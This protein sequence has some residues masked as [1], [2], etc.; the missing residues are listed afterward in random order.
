MARC[1]L[2]SFFLLL[3][4]L[5]GC[6]SNDRVTF[7]DGDIL[8]Q[9]LNSPQCQAVKIATG[10]QYSHCGMIN[11]I[12][13][14]LFVLEGLQPTMLTPVEEWIK[15]GIDDHYVVKRLKDL[16]AQMPRQVKEKIISA[17]EKYLGKDYDIY[18]GWSDSL[19]YCSGLVWKVYKEAWG[20]E[21]CPL[22]KLKDFNLSHPI[23]QAKLHERYGDNFPLEE[24]VV[25]PSD[26]FDSELLEE[27]VM[28]DITH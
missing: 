16:G 21:L 17:G 3:I 6:Q 28:E 10:S 5:F 25:A 13:G 19:I 1:H 7:Q 12:D 23:V 18:F 20:I 9:S 4:A 8:F 14:E 27:I 24:P 26:L 15:R 2:L 11:I 22:R